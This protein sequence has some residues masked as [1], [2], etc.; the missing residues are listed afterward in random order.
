[1]SGKGCGEVTGAFLFG[2]V[3]LWARHL[4]SRFSIAIRVTRLRLR[5]PWRG[6]FSAKMLHSLVV[7]YV[8]EESGMVHLRATKPLPSKAP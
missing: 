1:M 6:R 5:A 2:K 4:Q 3:P 8:G 7:I